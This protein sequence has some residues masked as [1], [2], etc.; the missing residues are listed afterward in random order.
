M[1]NKFFARQILNCWTDASRLESR[2]IHSLQMANKQIMEKYG[3][4]IFSELSKADAEIY[5]SFV[6]PTNL[7]I[8]EYQQFLMKLCKLTAES[9]NTK[10]FKSVMVDKYDGSKG[11]IAQLDDFLK[12]IE[13]D[14]EGI[15]YSSIKKCMIQEISWRGIVRQ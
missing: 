2:L 11:S 7:S 12:Y 14:S 1:E 6:I 13:L 9:I 5:R 10:L 15:V 8:P 3:N 4:V